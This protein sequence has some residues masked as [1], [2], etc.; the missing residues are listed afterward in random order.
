MEPSN[1]RK[2]YL[3][4]YHTDTAIFKATK[5]KKTIIAVI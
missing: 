4:N 3:Y 1:Y 5:N 2:L